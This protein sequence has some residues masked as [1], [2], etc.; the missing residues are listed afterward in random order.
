MVLHVLK[1][2]KRAPFLKGPEAVILVSLRMSS[3]PAMHELQ[4]EIIEKLVAS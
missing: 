1:I 3:F 4:R 2:R